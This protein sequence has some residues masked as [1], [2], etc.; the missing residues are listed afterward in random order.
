MSYKITIANESV[1]LKDASALS[2]TEMQQILAKIRELEQNP[3]PDG[4]AAKRLKEENLADFRLKIGNY[5]VL[6]DRNLEKKELVLYR[7]L[8]RSKVR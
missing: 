8:H 2:K 3:W 5:R 4:S 6:F 1:W 7:I